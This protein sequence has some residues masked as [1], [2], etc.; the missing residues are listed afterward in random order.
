VIQM[1]A[2]A[3]AK[4]PMH[5]FCFD[6]LMT[7]TGPKLSETL[8]GIKSSIIN[9]SIREYSVDSLKNTTVSNDCF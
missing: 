3:L 5:Y 2:A 7:P 6:D 4:R 9:K 1:I 8:D